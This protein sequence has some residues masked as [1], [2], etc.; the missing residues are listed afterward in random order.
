MQSDASNP[1]NLGNVQPL[2]RLGLNTVRITLELSV[3]SV[4]IKS[5][6]VL[7]VDFLIDLPNLEPCT[8]TSVSDLIDFDSET[9][10]C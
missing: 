1:C 3:D 9:Y 2:L 7:K 4:S 6:S 5:W 8:E 10:C